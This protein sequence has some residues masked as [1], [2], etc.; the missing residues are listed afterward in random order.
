MFSP[1][2]DSYV[3]FHQHCIAMRNGQQHGQQRKLMLP[4]MTTYWSL[5]QRNQRERTHLQPLLLQVVVLA[6]KMLEKPLPLPLPPRPSHLLR[7][8]LKEQVQEEMSPQERDLDLH[9]LEQLIVMVIYRGTLT[10]RAM[11]T[12]IAMVSIY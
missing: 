1:H 7:N 4:K 10:V 2:H 6:Q 8:A 3:P 5:H 11:S 12:A 9:N